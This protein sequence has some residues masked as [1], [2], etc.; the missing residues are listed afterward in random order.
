VR[1]VGG[2]RPPRPLGR[3]ALLEGFATAGTVSPTSPRSTAFAD[4]WRSFKSRFLADDGRIVDNGNGGVSHSE[5]QGWGMLFAVTAQDRAA[6]DLILDWTS[7]SLRRP[8]DALYTWRFVPTDRTPRDLNNAVDGDM[9]IATALA[10]AGRSWGLPDC[11]QAA[12]AIGR[13]I[14]RLLVQQAGSF[15]ALLPGVDGFE[16]AD[17]IIVNP[18]YYAFPMLTELEKLVP[19][20]KWSHLQQ[21][22]RKLL[23]QGRFGRWGLP[24]DW[25]R[26]GKKDSTLAPAAGWPP[27]FSYDAVRCPLWWCWQKLPVGPAVRSVDQFWSTSSPGSVPAWVDL[28]TDDVAP[29]PASVGIQAIIRLVRATVS[30]TDTMIYPSVADSDRYYDAALILLAHLAEQEMKQH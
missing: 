26:I 1:V 22:G 23:E 25:L 27:R 6:F 24:P 8:Q 16:N 9:F 15:T 11:L 2:L 29:Y 28:Q 18:S 10:R 7:R 4:G 17:A 14:L 13:D 21:D 30:Q 3:R 12:S 20:P 5:G 19:S